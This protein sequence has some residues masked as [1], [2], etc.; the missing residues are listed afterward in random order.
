MAPIGSLR[1]KRLGV[2]S[3]LWSGLD[4]ELEELAIAARL[5]L[6]SAGVVFVDADIPDLFEQTRKCHFRSPYMS[7]GPTSLP[8]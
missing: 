3:I 4:R 7:L 8:I 6:E 1:G 5:K 2:P